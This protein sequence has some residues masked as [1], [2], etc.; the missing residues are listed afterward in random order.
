MASATDTSE[1]DQERH[2]YITT[3]GRKTGMPHTVQLMF[4]IANGKIYLSHEGKYTDWMWNILKDGHVEFRI[5]RTKFKGRAHIVKGG[6]AFETG[7]H[8]LYLKY[9]GKAEEDIIDDW[10]SE[11][12]IAEILIDKGNLTKTNPT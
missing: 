6:E 12:T 5:G 4:A 3:K 7:K 10:F 9:Y 2:I 11:S 8:F 1:I